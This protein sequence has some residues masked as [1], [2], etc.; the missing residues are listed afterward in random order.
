MLSWNLM[1]YFHKF[2]LMNISYTNFIHHCDE[3]KLI[4]KKK[5][6]GGKKDDIENVH[7]IFSLTGSEIK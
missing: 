3:F 5:K 7:N 6:G 1:Q 2:H 4:K